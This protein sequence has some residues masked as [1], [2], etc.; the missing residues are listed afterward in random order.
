MLAKMLPHY[1]RKQARGR[2]HATLGGPGRHFGR[3]PALMS[4]S[5]PPN[6]LKPY[7]NVITWVGLLEY[8]IYSSIREAIFNQ[9][10]DRSCSNHQSLPKYG[11][12]AQQYLFL[13][14][15]RYDWKP[16]SQ[17]SSLKPVRVGIIK[18]TISRL[19]IENL[20]NATLVFHT[21]WCANHQVRLP[22]MPARTPSA[23]NRGEYHLDLN[24]LAE[25]IITCC[26]RLACF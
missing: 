3:P 11:T 7:E 5:S 16:G 23:A 2:Q 1:R 14:R 8:S 19:C 9:T 4:G 25:K 6:L 21:A 12:I 20:I 24:W 10:C 13:C 17:R 18:T 26:R 22:G 15:S